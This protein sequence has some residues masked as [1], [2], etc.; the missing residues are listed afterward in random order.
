MRRQ[1][2]RDAL[3]AAMWE[4]QQVQEKQTGEETYGHSQEVKE[5]QPVIVVKHVDIDERE[6]GRNIVTLDKLGFELGTGVGE[7]S[8]GFLMTTPAHSAPRTPGVL[9]TNPCSE[10]PAS[11]ASPCMF[12]ASPFSDASTRFMPPMTP[13]PHAGSQQFWSP[14]PCASSRSGGFSMSAFAAEVSVAT[15]TSSGTANLFAP[16]SV[17]TSPCSPS[18][19]SMVMAPSPPRVPRVEAWMPSP[20]GQ[21]AANTLQVLFGSGTTP[22]GDVIVAT[23]KAAVP[24]VY[25]D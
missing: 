14:S 25:E 5:Q 11:A 6:R 2:Q 3:R 24:E 22:A 9:S 10:S 21:S 18:L 16:G 7:T 12:R 20:A 17:A 1:R 23:L 8:Q 15:V 4:N 13:Q 19:D